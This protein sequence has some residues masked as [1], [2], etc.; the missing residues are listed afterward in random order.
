M[1]IE[2]IKIVSLT[3]LLLLVVGACQNESHVPSLSISE[4]TVSFA[5]HHTA[6]QTITITASVE[7]WTA[8]AEASWVKAI[9]QERGD[10]LT[11]RVDENTSINQ[12]TA[13]VKIF[14]DG[15]LRSVQVTQAG[16]GRA[17]ELIPS[18]A[19]F[20]Q[21]GGN[22][23]VYVKGNYQDWSATCDAEWI[24]MKAYPER[25]IIEISVPENKEDTERQATITI[26]LPDGTQVATYTLRQDAI[27]TI[28]LPSLEFGAQPVD[29][30]SFESKRRSE[31]IKIPDGLINAT[32]W[33][34]KTVSPIFDRIEYVF[35]GGIYS[36]AKMYAKDKAT[37]AS[38]LDR[39]VELLL[40]M[41]FVNE[42]GAVYV[43]Q[44]LN[45]RVRIESSLS[46]PYVHFQ[47]DPKQPQDYP[48]FDE[49]PYG[50]LR[51]GLADADVIEEYEQAHGGTLLASRSKPTYRFY[52]INDGPW[53]HR[54][55][56]LSATSGK[57]IMSLSN[58]NLAVFLYAGEPFLTKE[59]KAL[60]AK[61]GFVLLRYDSSIKDFTFRNDQKKMTLD[62]RVGKSL[63]DA[64]DPVLFFN[65]LY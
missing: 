32:T 36:S 58:I 59:F 44:D 61:E 25:N 9:R 28:I 30:R 11:I 13:E 1:A 62:V 38:V 48:T 8:F 18:E 34:F 57:K 6:E 15:L 40:G 23:S 43:N 19:H 2:K 52:T 14:A 50:L 29:I 47:L 16:A 12:R 39:F 41:G 37:M 64:R 5:N 51:Y 21:F 31:V 42:Y 17:L 60:M 56:Y 10:K 53:I 7:D 54:A 63:I 33:G 24:V 4:Q 49:F 27:L 35:D 22:T 65:L 3:I 46:Q 45:T 26:A 20:D 55:Y